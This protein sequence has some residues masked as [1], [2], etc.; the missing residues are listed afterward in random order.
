[1]HSILLVIEKPNPHADQKTQNDYRGLLSD[2]KDITRDDVNIESLSENVLL[3]EVST[4]LRKFSRV[5]S[6]ADFPY[7]CIFFE[8]K[9]EWVI[10]QQNPDLNNAFG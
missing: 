8:D 9:P 2:I 3:F 10:Q 4:A 7:K 6:L 1:M 5:L